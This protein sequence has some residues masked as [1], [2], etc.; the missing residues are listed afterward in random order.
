MIPQ[1]FLG[2]STAANTSA[3]NT[4]SGSIAAEGDAL[5]AGDG[6]NYAH[7][8]AY[9]TVLQNP[10]SPGFSGTL[11]L[12]SD[13]NDAD[14]INAI[15]IHFKGPTSANGYLD[16][17]EANAL[18]PGFKVNIDDIV[19][20]SVTSVPVPAAVWMFGSGLLGMLSLGRR[21]AA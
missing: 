19:L 13:F 4:A 1:V 14:G 7:R 11:A 5:A 16:A 21:K 6:T 10:N 2:F 18:T 20:E 15:W 17:T 9:Q 12:N 3:M 8:V